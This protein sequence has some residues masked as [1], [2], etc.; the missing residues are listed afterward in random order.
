LIE[1]LQTIPAKQ[2]PAILVSSGNLLIADREWLAGIPGV[3]I[4]DKPVAL[5]ELQ[6]MVRQALAQRQRS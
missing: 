1:H 5:R 4:I 6:F 3:S 2:R